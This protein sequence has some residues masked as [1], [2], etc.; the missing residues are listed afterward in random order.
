MQRVPNSLCKLTTFKKTRFYTNTNSYTTEYDNKILTV[1]E[2][3]KVPYNFQA[4]NK[5]PNVIIDGHALVQSSWETPDC[6]MV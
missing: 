5:P 2:N 1:Y 4:L 6:K 3:I